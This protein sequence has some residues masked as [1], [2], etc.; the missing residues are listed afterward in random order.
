MLEGQDSNET[1]LRGIKQGQALLERNYEVF[2][3]R[4]DILV[5]WNTR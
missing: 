1:R 4:C 5:I 2:P 3:E